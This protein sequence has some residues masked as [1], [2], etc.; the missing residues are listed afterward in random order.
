MTC[1]DVE[2]PVDDNGIDKAELTKRGTKLVQ[3][4][5]EWVRALLT[6]GISL[7][8]GTSCISLVVFI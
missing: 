5:G 4:S 1:Y 2:I 6:Y 7:S 3:L 8:I